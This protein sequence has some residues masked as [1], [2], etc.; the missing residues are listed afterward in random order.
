MLLNAVKT[1]SANIIMKY[2]ISADLPAPAA[3][4]LLNLPAVLAQFLKLFE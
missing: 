3:V 2:V 1:G 4:F